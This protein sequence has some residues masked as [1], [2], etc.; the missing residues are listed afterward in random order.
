MIAYIKGTVEEVS[1]DIVVL[2]VSGVGYNIKIPSNIIGYLPSHGELV[3]IHTYTYVR[4]DCF[5]LYGFLTK[6][7]L[8]LFKK[9]ITVNGVGPKAGLS[10]LSTMDSNSFILSILA[11]DL[12]AISKAPGI[13]TK[14][15]QRIIL[16]LKDKVSAE[17]FYGET[18]ECTMAM[19]DSQ[20]AIKNEALEAL[21]SLGYSST[22]AMSAIN[23]I[24][25]L[26]NLTI[27]SVLKQALKYMF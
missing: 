15:A 22:E 21:V 26:D 3:K 16:D 18:K 10:I 11:Q 1:E 17:A 9:L 27:E 6:E 24:P 7:D 4:E 5:S 23:K 8:E 25:S 20:V 13:G 19:P 12:K 2:D 14:T